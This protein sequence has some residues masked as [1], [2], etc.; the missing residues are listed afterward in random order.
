MALNASEPINLPDTVSA[1]FPNL[2]FSFEGHV[3]YIHNTTIQIATT[4]TPTRVT[5]INPH[6]APGMTVSQIKYVAF[7]GRTFLVVLTTTSTEI[8]SPDAS[9]RVYFAL[10]EQ[11]KSG[12]RP[13]HRGV[14]VVGQSLLI[15][16]SDGTLMQL[17]YA[18]GT[19]A[20]VPP[21]EGGM[22]AVHQLPVADVVGLPLGSPAP[23]SPLHFATACDRSVALWELTPAG[24]APRPLGKID[25]TSP[26]TC[27]DRCGALLFAATSSG[28]VAVFRDC[29]DRIQLICA[30]QLHALGVRAMD[31]HP[32]TVLGGQGDSDCLLATCAEDSTL[33]LTRVMPDGDS[34]KLVPLA[35]QSATD[36]LPC[37]IQFRV[38]AGG[39]PVTL[40]CA[41]YDRTVLTCY[42]VLPAQ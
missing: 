6:P 24:A 20:Q 13:H 10:V 23:A 15:G 27:L 21:A 19:F 40:M 11:T 36:R 1:I 3:A 7:E 37:G 9:E 31:A 42:D 28:E 17:R 39:A 14:A 26:V 34:I 18:N 30:A 5:T 16:T 33:R 12:K 8:W 29:P 25:L 35:M 41:N 4:T 32:A 38:G 2:T 22:L